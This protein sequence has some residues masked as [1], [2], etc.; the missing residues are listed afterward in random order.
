MPAKK[1]TLVLPPG[2]SSASTTDRA[3]QF[4]VR[5]VKFRAQGHESF[6]P[7]KVDKELWQ[8]RCSLC[9]NSMVFEGKIVDWAI[10]RAK[11]D[12]WNR[13]CFYG[14]CCSCI[15]RPENLRYV[16][17]S[18]GIMTDRPATKKEHDSAIH[19]PNN[20][21]NLWRQDFLDACKV[22]AEFDE[23]D[24]MYWLHDGTCMEAARDLPLDERMPGTQ[25][26]SAAIPSK[27]PLPKLQATAKR[28]ET[29]PNWVDGERHRPILSGQQRRGVMELREAIQA[30]E[31][32]YARLIEMIEKVGRHYSPETVQLEG[33]PVVL[34]AW[35]TLVEKQYRRRPLA[36]NPTRITPLFEPHTYW[37]HPFSPSYTVHIEVNY[38]GFHR[39]GIDRPGFNETSSFRLLEAV[40]GEQFEPFPKA[41]SDGKPLQPKAYREGLTMMLQGFASLVEQHTGVKVTVRC[42][43]KIVTL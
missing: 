26:V 43:H 23:L 8:F 16:D 12:D 40:K 14:W 39:C 30:G 42:E 4:R 25:S 13:Y 21:Y 31:W 20:A 11:E 29:S 36:D 32:A 28:R 37:S 6:D 2:Y 35:M 17:P 22:R 18:S 5:M 9:R 27:E 41:G 34:S 33:Q 15:T 24:E 19:N 1:P 7:I 38:P 3:E 10:H